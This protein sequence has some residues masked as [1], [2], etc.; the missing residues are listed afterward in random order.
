MTPMFGS[1][2]GSEKITTWDRLWTVLFCGTVLSNVCVSV[3]ELEEMLVEFEEKLPSL[4]D[5]LNIYLKAF[6]GE[7]VDEMF[8]ARADD[9]SAMVERWMRE[10]F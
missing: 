1:R 4:V 3:V 6:F 9:V 5:S 8:R 7:D 10:L 2:K